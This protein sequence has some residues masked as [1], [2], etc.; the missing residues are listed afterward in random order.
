MSQRQFW[1][2]MIWSFHV[3]SLQDT[4]SKRGHTT[5]GM[6]IHLHQIQSTSLAKK[7]KDIVYALF[8]RLGIILDASTAPES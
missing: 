3:Q 7:K 4:W 5:S 2:D 1:P 8:I 6:L